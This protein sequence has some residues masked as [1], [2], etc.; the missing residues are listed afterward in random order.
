MR[1]SD[2]WHGHVKATNNSNHDYKHTA[3]AAPNATLPITT[4]MCAAAA[5]SSNDL[6]I[7][8]ISLIAIEFAVLYL[9]IAKRR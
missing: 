8:I 3:V 4:T 1:N 7:I 6:V 5:T 2:S 9:W